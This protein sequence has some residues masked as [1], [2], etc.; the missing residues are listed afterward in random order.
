MSNSNAVESGKTS[1]SHSSV[2][3]TVGLYKVQGSIRKPRLYP[4]H[5]INGKFT[6]S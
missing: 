4:Y 1:N 3:R 6:I 5:H 2:M